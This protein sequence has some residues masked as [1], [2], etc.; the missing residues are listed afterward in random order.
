MIKNI[1]ELLEALIKAETE[2]L[3]EEDIPHRVTIGDMYEELTAEI[4]ERSVFEGLN[5][6][7]VVGSFIQNSPG[8]YSKEMDVMIIE[9][10]AKRIGRTKRFK[11]M[12]EQ[13]IAVIQV[14]KTLNKQQ[15]SKAYENLKDVYDISEWATYPDYTREIFRNSFLQICKKDVIDRGQ[16]RKTFADKTEEQLFH[17]LALEAAMP[18]RI[19]IGYEGYATEHSLRE[20]IYE[21]MLDNLSTPDQLKHGYSPLILPNLII[22][23]GISL[24]KGN[25]Q[26]YVGPVIDGQWAFYFSHPSNPMVHLLEMIWTRL[27][28]RFGL[29]SDIFGEDLEID[30]LNTL[31][32][33]NMVNVGGIQAWNLEYVPTSKERLEEEMIIRSWKPVSLTFPEF[34]LISYLINVGEIYVAKIKDLLDR[35]NNSFDADVFIKPLIDSHL[36][37]IDTI[38]K[39]KLATSECRVLHLKDKGFFA[40]DDRSGRLSRWAAK[41]QSEDSLD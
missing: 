13:V 9:G 21:F 29:S 10:E 34:V 17:M 3:A 31:F 14:K 11:V 37:V 41:M 22:N 32:L 36:V 25:A 27:T 6:N 12:P 1:A 38:G 15:L 7:V 30:G 40:A 23:E 24:I 5:L 8:V 28:Y 4:I 33:A 26:P 16:M 18:I 20:G 2:L 19:L 39:I 35:E